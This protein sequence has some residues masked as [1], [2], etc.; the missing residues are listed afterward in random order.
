MMKSA[1]ACLGTVIFVLLTGCVGTKAG[2]YRVFAEDLERLKGK[3]LS[4]SYVFLIGY[5]AKLDPKETKE[6]TNG[7]EIR[8]YAVAEQRKQECTIFIEVDPKTNFIIEA[9]SKG[10]DCWRPY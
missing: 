9:S 8:V 10:P 7:N 3:E 4:K 5:L 6:L 2:A 1:F